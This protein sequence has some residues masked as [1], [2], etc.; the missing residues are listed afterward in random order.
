M[1]NSIYFDN[2]ATTKPS[3]TVIE[4]IN[5][6]LSEN[7]GNPSSTHNLGI[8]ADEELQSAKQTVAETV[9]ATADEIIFTGSG[10][11][12][13]NLA[14][15][16]TADKLKRLGNR[17]VTTA[18]EHPS[19][20]NAMEKL[21]TLGFEI[22]KMKPNGDGVI[23]E[24]E[25]KNAINDKT[26]LVSVMLVNNEIGSVQNIEFAKKYI[27][28]SGA[29]AYFHCDAVQGYGKLP[30]DVKKSGIDLLS[31][32]GHKIHGPKGIGFLYKSKK[33]NISPLIYGGGQQGGL[34]SG[35]EPM[36]LIMGLKGAAEEIK[37]VNALLKAQIEFC[38]YA[39][40]KLLETGK[41]KINSPDEASPYI[42]N[43]SVNGYKSEPIL[44]ALSDKGI[45]VS[46]GSACSKGHRSYVLKECDFDTDTI[47]SA[48]RLSFSRYNTKEEIDCFCE[49]ILD[50]TSKMRR[51]K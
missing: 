30:I 51:Y 45:Y 48:L 50:I 2:S 35:T 18:I 3:N 8:I 7:W 17:I 39:K 12:A 1:K 34:R 14:I 24:E 28:Q 21:S 42:L 33:V 19:V 49:A 15:F 32:S 23:P 6:S 29:P 31:A 38:N 43:I 22:I 40:E 44:N 41:I 36:P 11:E 10:S 27:L 5:R 20:L 26:I 46:T 13:N 16:G 4:Y 9:N 47:D 37:N 25:F